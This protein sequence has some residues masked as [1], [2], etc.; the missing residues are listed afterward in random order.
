MSRFDKKKVMPR[1]VA[2]AV[3]MTL[4]GLAIIL[5]TGYIMIVQKDYW[6]AVAASQKQIN[7]VKIEKPTR[8]NIFSCDGQIMASTIPIYEMH[9]DFRPDEQKGKPRD[10]AVVHKLD[11]LWMEN[12]DS[13]CAGLAEIFPSR[14]AM[15]YKE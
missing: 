14:T 15:Q 1:Y 10:T 8:G 6:L 5:R 9:I 12:I 7:N 4:V 11:T 3:A 2:I 13:L